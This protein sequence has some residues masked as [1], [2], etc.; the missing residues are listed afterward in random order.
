MWT[1]FKVFLEFVTLLF[2]FYVLVFSYEAPGNLSS[3]PGIEPNPP[4][5]EDDVLTTGQPGKPQFP[6]SN[7]P[8]SEPIL[9]KKVLGT[10]PQPASI[11]NRA[12]DLD[13]AHS[14]QHRQEIR[15][16]GHIQPCLFPWQTCDGCK[17][18]WRCSRQLQRQGAGQEGRARLW[19]R[20]RHPQPGGW[21]RNVRAA[22]TWMAWKATA[23]ANRDWVGGRGR[24]VGHRSIPSRP[25]RHLRMA[26]TR[27]GEQLWTSA[28]WEGQ[29]HGCP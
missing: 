3:W 24:F 9:E 20:L 19:W 18:K 27:G 14:S 25:G 10:G 11:E 29:Q 4:A 16:W 7:H 28:G 23:A 2:L 22:P 17:R 13:E 5:L 15:C 1:I 12:L 21:N 26:F 8:L 6:F